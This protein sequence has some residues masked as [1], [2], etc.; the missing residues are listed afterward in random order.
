M[1]PDQGVAPRRTRVIKVDPVRPDLSSIREAARC[2]QRGGLVVFPTE[3]VYGLGADA[4]DGRA[5]AGIFAAKGRPPDNPLIVHVASPADVAPLAREIDPRAEALMRTFW[6]GPLSL[7]FPR[8]SRVAPEV[9]CGLDTV[10][11]RMPRHPVALELVRLAG[12]PVAAPSANTSGR[13]SPTRAEDVVSDLEGRVD[14]ILDA[15]PCPVGVESTVLD[16]TGAVPTVL[17]PGGVT[18]ESLRQVIGRVDLLAG[19]AGTAGPAARSPGLRHRHYSPRARLVLVLPAPARAGSSASEASTAAVVARV[20]AAE[21]AAGLKVG[22]ACTRETSESLATAWPAAATRTG[23]AGSPGAVAP[24]TSGGSRDAA[25]LPRVIVWGARERPE[26]VATRLFSALRDLDGLGMDVIVAEGAAPEGLGVAVNDRLERAAA[27]IVDAGVESRDESRAAA[28]SAIPAP[29]AP[30]ELLLLICSGNTCRSP[31]AAAILDDLLRREGLA[32]AY[33]VDSAGTSAIAG[34]PASPEALQVMAERGLDLSGHASK[35]IS[36]E[37]AE[38]A[39]LILTMTR[40]HRDVVTR[41]CPAAADRTYTIKGYAGTAPQPRASPGSRATP[42]P[43]QAP[44]PETAPQP[45]AAAAGVPGDQESE[46]ISDPI[47]RG[48]EAYREA[49]GEIERAAA[50]V[51]ERLRS[52]PDLTKLL[53]NGEGTKA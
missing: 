1:K 44:N 10:A 22:V 31:M 27:S 12:L 40:P 33:R 53:G 52:L 38:K 28:P 42:E 35:P 21:M 11:I 29:A 8:T 3:T 25:A 20:A 13:P 7:I 47:G 46:D 2:L 16:L 23:A 30:P 6:P 15:G 45:G 49:A 39:R 50:G 19:A 37:L 5:V 51:V 43:G 36:P 4:T 24:P 17:R 14:Y 48:L 32:A 26:E 41:L 9:C 18:V 34:Q